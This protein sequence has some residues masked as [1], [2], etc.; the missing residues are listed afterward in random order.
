MEIFVSLTLTDNIVQ[1]NEVI[2]K[3]QKEIL[4]YYIS[5]KIFLKGLLNIATKMCE[6]KL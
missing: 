6:I 5:R 2:P 1:E 4:K 3:A